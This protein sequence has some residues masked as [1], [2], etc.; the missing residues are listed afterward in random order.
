MKRSAFLKSTIL[1]TSLAVMIPELKG[2]VVKQEF[3]ELRTYLFKNEAQQKLVENYFEKA[4]IPALNRIGS[5]NIGVFREQKTEGQAKL[6][7]L[8]PFQS[9]DDF[10]QADEKLSKD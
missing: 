4:A 10:L 8:I 9:M 5:K 1:T 3:Y 6:H 7:V 2:K